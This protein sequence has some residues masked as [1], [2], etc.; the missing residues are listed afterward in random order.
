MIISHVDGS[1]KVIETLI[2]V[3]FKD[4]RL[5]LAYKSPASGARGIVEYSHAETTKII[6]AIM[7]SK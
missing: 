5:L 2:T 3:T 1:K 4:G 7:G 6:S